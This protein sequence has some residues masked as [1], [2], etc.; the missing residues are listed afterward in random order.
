MKPLMAP[1]QESWIEALFVRFEGLYGNQ[2]IE[3]W[4]NTDIANAKQVWAET[5]AGVS[6]EQIKAALIECGKT[7]K[8]PPSAPEF[9]QL[10]KAVRVD[11]CHVPLLCKPIVKQADGYERVQK[12]KEMLGQKLTG[13]S[14]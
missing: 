1:L 4:R 10:C 3:K 9:Y 11:P 5:L 14:D 12:L 2:F 8:F 7:C 6:A 13:T